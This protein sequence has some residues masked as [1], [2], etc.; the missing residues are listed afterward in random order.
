[1]E[2]NSVIQHMCRF[3]DS[4]ASRKTVGGKRIKRGGRQ[5]VYGNNF[6]ELHIS[7]ENSLEEVFKI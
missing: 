3:L 2:Y 5:K 4:V 1:M 7:W 6:S